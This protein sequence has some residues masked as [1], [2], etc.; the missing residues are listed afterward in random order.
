MPSGKKKLSAS[1]VSLSLGKLNQLQTSLTDD[2][3]KLEA[4]LP[5]N[6]EN[7]SEALERYT[8]VLNVLIR[9][10][11]LLFQREENLKSKIGPNKQSKK[12]IIAELDTALDRLLAENDKTSVPRKSE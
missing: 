7:M 2:L 6:A 12:E 8:K 9:S 3:I 11:N 4:S 1:G 5:D 10:M